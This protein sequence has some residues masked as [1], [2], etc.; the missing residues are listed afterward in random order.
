MCEGECYDVQMVR[1][2]FIK[3][4][5]LGFKL[6]RK[7]AYNMCEPCEYNQLH[8]PEVSKRHKRYDKVLSKSIL[9]GVIGLCVGDALG[10]PVQFERRERFLN[11]PVT[12][13]TGYGTFNLP[14]GSWSDDTS[15]TLCLLDSLSNGLDYNDIMKKFASWLVNGEYTPYGKAYDIGGTTRASIF[16]YVN[17]IELMKCGGTNENDNGNGSLMRTL[18]IAFYLHSKY[19]SRFSD[20]D[21]AFDIIH[22]VSALTHAHE[23]SMIACGI[24]CTLAELLINENHLKDSIKLGLSTSIRYYLSKNEFSN[25]C[26]YYNRLFDDSFFDLPE[27]EIKSSGYVVDTLEAAIWCLMN[28]DSYEKCVLRAVNLGG[29]T[30]TIAAVAGGLAGTYYGFD[31][32]PKKWVD[33]IPQLDYIKELCKNCFS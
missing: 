13:M 33:Q 9:G 16:K 8:S 24:Y 1:A 18:P 4:S 6:D 15:M 7:V 27:S 23:R 12:D 2:K 17:G 28:S 30:D 29:D 19:S 5:R 22:N 3:K 21:E 11:A 14:P 10:L 25:E 32:I 31:A 26:R 20:N